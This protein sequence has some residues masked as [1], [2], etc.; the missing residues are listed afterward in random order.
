MNGKCK[1]CTG[2]GLCELKDGVTDNDLCNGSK[3]DMLWC[4]IVANNAE[5]DD[6]NIENIIRRWYLSYR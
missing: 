3:G 6:V 1:W 4:S 5:H 2:E